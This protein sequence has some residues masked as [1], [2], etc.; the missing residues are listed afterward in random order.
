MYLRVK[1]GIN[2]PLWNAFLFIYF[3]TCKVL[4]LLI[5]ELTGGFGFFLV[6]KANWYFLNFKG[7][8]HF[9]KFWAYNSNGGGAKGWQKV[10]KLHVFVHVYFYAGLQK[11]PKMVNC[12]L[13]LQIIL[14]IK[15]IQFNQ[16]VLVNLIW[17]IQKPKVMKCL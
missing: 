9:S 4:Y 16:K 1:S 2:N 10:G 17:L 14:L 7:C 8:Y 3:F 12:C 11:A 15:M 6:L 13:R 5:L